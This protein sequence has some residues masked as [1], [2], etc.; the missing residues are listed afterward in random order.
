MSDPKLALQF[1]DKDMRSLFRHACQILNREMDCQD[2]DAATLAR[3]KCAE[4]VF[5][6]LAPSLRELG[7]VDADARRITWEEYVKGL[8][9]EEKTI[10]VLEGNGE[11]PHPEEPVS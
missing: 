4:I 9:P 3:I 8:K 10:I 2:A 6:Y 7:K 5:R 11:T 1:P